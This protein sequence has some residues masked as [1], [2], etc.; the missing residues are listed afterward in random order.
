MPLPTIAAAQWYE[1][2]PVADGVTLIHEPWMTPFFRCNMWLIEGTDRALLLDAGLG[3]VPLREA[4]PAVGFDRSMTLLLSHTHFD[5]IGGAH[6]FGER[7]M[8]RDEMGIAAAPTSDA[9]LFATYS[10]GALD[11]AMFT[12]LPPGWNAG[13][14]AVQPAAAT[15]FV[16][17]G[18]RIALGGRVLTVLHTPG[19]SPGHL[20]LFEEKTGTLFAQDAL[21]DGPLVDD[22]YHSDKAVYAQT[23]RRLLDL[24]P[25]IVHGGH[26]GSFGP[27]RFRALIERYLADR[28]AA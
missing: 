11:D 4:V 18:D 5:H 6:E 7:L 19:H 14:H 2:I 24:R 9:T 3:A 10:D 20:S 23:L 27:E 26:F 12:G 21:Y 13:T 28:D 16:E 22:A 25:R 8:H 1:T 17:D 15:G